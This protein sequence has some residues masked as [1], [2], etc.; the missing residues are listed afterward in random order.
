M[1]KRHLFCILAM[2]LS[3]LAGCGHH[4]GC[5]LCD[6][7]ADIPPGAIPQPTGAHTCTWNAAQAGMAES[8]DFVIYQYEWLEQSHDLGP[9]GRRHVDQLAGRLEMQPFQVIIETSESAELD[10]SRRA[11]IID[12]LAERGLNNAESR[13]AIGYGVAEGLMG[14]EAP[15]LGQGNL[16]SGSRGARGSAFGGAGGFGGTT[17]FGGSSGFGGFGGFGGTGGVF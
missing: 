16:Q 1:S 2:T 9:F 11:A 8:D 10:E 12:R 4:H 7:C 15:R 6:D 14:D 13:V 5:L 17:G 3:S